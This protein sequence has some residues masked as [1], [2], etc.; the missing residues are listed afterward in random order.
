MLYVQGQGRK[1]EMCII[2]VKG[3]AIGD[4]QIRSLKGAMEA[5]GAPMGI[6]LTLKE[7]TKPMIAN[8]AAAGFWETDWGQIPRVQI[9]TV[10]AL[11]TSAV[12]PLRI[13]MA[14]SDSYRKAA[15]E[16]RSQQGALDL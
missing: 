1:T 7:P 12:P 8:A 16:D 14:R 5:Q 3:G 9:V 6:F 2:E 10:E 15:R 11:L 13:P 4:A